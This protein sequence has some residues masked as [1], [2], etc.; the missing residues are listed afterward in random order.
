MI[1]CF[2]I[3][4]TICTQEKVYSDAKPFKD[5]ALYQERFSEVVMSRISQIK[6]EDSDQ[7]DEINECLGFD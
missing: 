4:G 3:D 5:K 6:D 2:D 1:Y 7:M